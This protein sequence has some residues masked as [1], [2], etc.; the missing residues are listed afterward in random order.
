MKKCNLWRDGSLTVCHKF[1]FTTQRIKSMFLSKKNTL[2]VI[3]SLWDNRATARSYII[4]C[5]LLAWFA[6]FIYDW[7]EWKN[8]SRLSNCGTVRLFIFGH[9]SI[10]FTLIRYYPLIRIQKNSTQDVLFDTTRILNFRL[11]YF[12]DENRTYIPSFNDNFCIKN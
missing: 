2:I 1:W 12:A 7:N 3:R 5:T 8:Y 10:Q 4:F 6:V 11:D 9:F